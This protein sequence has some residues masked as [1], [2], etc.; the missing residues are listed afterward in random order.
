[1]TLNLS[2]LRA[3]TL[4]L[5]DGTT[6]G[7]WS[8][9]INDAGDKW[10]GWPLSVSADNIEDKTIIRPGGHW[11]YEWDAK[12]SQHEAC[13][14]ARLIAAAPTLAA[15]TL[16]LLDEI[17]R[18]TDENERMR[19][20]RDQ[21]ARD[22]CD[23]MEH[24]DRQHVQIAKLEAALRPF[25]KYVHDD[26]RRGSATYELVAVDRHGGGLIGAEDLR[27]ARAA[28]AEGGPDDR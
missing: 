2:K 20:D 16:R 8:V 13:Q 12:T 22:Y 11:P 10:T 19:A 24:R 28:L 5:I 23:L 1:M 25:V 3:D 15:D 27:R 6:P 7:P 26:L 21:G 18:L 9:F 4:A 14:N 17:E